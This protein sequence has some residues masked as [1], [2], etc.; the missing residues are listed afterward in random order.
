MSNDTQLDPTWE[1]MNRTLKYHKRPLTQ[2]KDRMKTTQQ[3][4]RELQ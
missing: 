4:L 1:F 3:R 2:L